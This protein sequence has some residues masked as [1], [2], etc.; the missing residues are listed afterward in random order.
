MK[1]KL[2]VPNSQISK[3]SLVRVEA[4]SKV[5]TKLV[6]VDE[7]STGSTETE[8]SSPVI[9]V[10]GS[11]KAME[12][13]LEVTLEATLETTEAEDWSNPDGVGV[14]KSEAKGIIEKDAPVSNTIGRAEFG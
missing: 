10:Y 4:N 3:W 8:T 11:I 9:K 1:T 7:R 5:S 12:A 13:V 14:R 2:A 6:S